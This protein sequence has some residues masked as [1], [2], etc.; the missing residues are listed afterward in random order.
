MQNNPDN[1][2]DRFGQPHFDEPMQ[3]AE[4][5]LANI[6]DSFIDHADIDNSEQVEEERLKA[7]AHLLDSAIRLPG[8]FRIGLDGIVGLVPGIGDLL[9]AGLSGYLIYGAYRLNIPRR[10]IARMIINT[11]LETVI[12]TIPVAGDIFDF[13]FKANERNARLLHAALDARHAKRAAIDDNAPS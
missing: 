13:A 5:N 11:I 7:Y 2:P 4:P 6:E 9:G 3:K 12:G 8:G 10:V 1:K